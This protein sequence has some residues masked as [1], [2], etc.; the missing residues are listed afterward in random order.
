MQ[1]IESTKTNHLHYKNPSTTKIEHRPPCLVLAWLTGASD[2]LAGQ[3][4]A[5][6]V[7]ELV[8]SRAVDNNTGGRRNKIRKY[9]TTTTGGLKPLGQKIDTK[10]PPLP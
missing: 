3:M 7:A 10:A 9:E 4:L 2:R 8:L 1:I 5:E 6:G